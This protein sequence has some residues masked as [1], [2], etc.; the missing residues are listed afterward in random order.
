MTPSIAPIALFSSLVLTAT[1]ASAQILTII[2]DRLLVNGTESRNVAVTTINEQKRTIKMEIFDDPCGAFSEKVPGQVRCLAA[3]QKIDELAGSYPLKETGGCGDQYRTSKGFGALEDQPQLRVTD[4]SNPSLCDGEPLYRF[5]VLGVK[6][7]K[8]YE[9]VSNRKPE[10]DLSSKP[11]LNQD[12]AIF[13]AL[14]VE[15]KPV[16]AITTVNVREKK[17]SGLVC[18]EIQSKFESTTACLYEGQAVSK[19][20]KSK[21]S[22]AIYLALRVEEVKE[23]SSQ[24]SVATKT[25]GRLMCQKSQVFGPNVSSSPVYT[26][27]LL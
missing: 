2:S 26:C 6:N 20:S 21:E 4:Y 3:P 23:F 10:L 15:A 14:N 18:Q 5:S 12:H 1:S 24:L 7:A 25:V 8:I 13:E 17:V 27:W 11:I 22:K 9:A 19:I 16:V